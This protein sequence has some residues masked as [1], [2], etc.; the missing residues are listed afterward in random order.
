MHKRIYKLSPDFVFEAF[1]DG[2]LVL[3][4]ANLSLTELNLTARD[5]LNLTDGQKTVW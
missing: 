3:S 2:A 5:I 4:T 1:E